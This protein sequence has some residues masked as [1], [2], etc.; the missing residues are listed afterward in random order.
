MTIY[1]S[2][3]TI[4]HNRQQ[5]PVNPG[6][7]PICPQQKIGLHDCVSPKYLLRHCVT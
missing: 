3:V 1:C 2:K 5:Y 4:F 7:L 6:P